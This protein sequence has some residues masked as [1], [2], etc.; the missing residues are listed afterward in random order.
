MNIGHYIP[1]IKYT[2]YCTFSLNYVLNLPI[3][4]AKYCQRVLN[5]SNNDAGT[6]ILLSKCQQ[7]AFQPDLAYENQLIAKNISPDISISLLENIASILLD[8]ENLE[9]SLI[10]YLKGYKKRKQPQDFIFGIIE[11]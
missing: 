5:V 11:V 2:S 4:A 1:I 9:I 10:T 6:R 8:K 3:L 7:N